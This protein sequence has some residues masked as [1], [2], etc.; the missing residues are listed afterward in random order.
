MPVYNEEHVVAD[1]VRRLHAYLSNGFPY[2]AVV[3]VVDNASSDATFEIA[4]RLAYELDGVN[5]MRLRAKGRGRALRAAW[6][7]SDARVVA[8]MDVDLST[9]LSA[10]QPLVE[11]LLDGRSDLAVGSRLARGA[12][13]RRSLLRELISRTYNLI[14]RAGLRSRISD[15]QCGFK[16]GRREAVQ[17]LLPLVEDEDW[18]FDTELI[19]HAERSGLR[20]HEVPVD[21]TEDPDSRVHLISTAIE[22][23]RGIAR[24]RRNE[25]RRAGDR[26]RATE[27]RARMAVNAA[28]VRPAGRRLTIS[29]E[30]RSFVVI[31]L[32]CTAAYA[33]LYTAFRHLGVGALASN[34]MAL[35]T[36]MGANF[37]A[38]R[39]FSFKASDGPLASQLASYVVAYLIG[40]GASSVVLSALLGALG[41]PA[42][43]ADTAAALA[44]GLVAT[45]VR[46]V[47]MRN[48]VFR[49]VSALEGAM[50]APARAR[51]DP[52]E[53]AGSA[54][55][56]L[57]M[58]RPELIALLVLAAVLDLWAL[59]QN[60]W[61]NDYYS[62][63]V[64][65]MSSS[66]HNFLYGSFDPSGIMTVDKPPLALWVQAL[67]ARLFGFHPLSILVPQALM[68]VASVALVYDLTRRRFGRVAGF[69]GRPRARHHA[70]DRGD[71]P[72]QQP[73]R[74]ARALLGGRALVPGARAR[75]RA[76]ALARAV[77][78]V[79]RP[80]LRDEDGRGADGA[81]GHRGRLA[82]GRAARP[83]RGGQAAAR[84]AAP[85]WRPSAC[86]WPLLV[87]LTPAADRPWISGTSDN[88]VWSLI[89]GYN[90]LG[91]LDGQAGGP[92]GVGNGGPFG[93]SAGPLRLFNAALGGQAGWLLGV[94]VVGCDRA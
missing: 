14:V 10:L 82:V 68:G 49:R 63:A 47:L 20:I 94:A 13:V 64:R 78:R 81:A 27:G 62:A 83:L 29:A 1:N 53:R 16:A 2:S 84:A 37:A 90:G 60:G 24:L 41:H 76:H 7:G 44:A 9:D 32:L 45:A 5:V 36:T 59:G 57:R 34:A 26:S 55:R 67:S 88:S 18:F 30:L 79:D 35:T 50:P 61:A 40:L 43:A 38:N 70:N 3:T 28:T 46:Y 91:R 42:G 6:T 8:Y 11:P 71:L 75:G 33:L 58:P 52:L 80:R 93:G 22:D 69:V 56:A 65:S 77:G 51:V 23:L 12:R 19:H 21:W 86:A 25:R 54:V 92:A 15:A 85:P 31:G 73:G 39:R 74:A 4:H 72:P 17:A 89:F 87:T 48:W 66:W